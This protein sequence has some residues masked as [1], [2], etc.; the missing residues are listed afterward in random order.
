MHNKKASN[1]PQFDLQM[2]PDIIFDIPAFDNGYYCGFSTSYFRVKV[3][4]TL[5]N[6][7][8]AAVGATITYGNGYV[9]FESGLESMF[10]RVLIQ[11]ASGNLLENFENYNYLYCPT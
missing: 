10:R 6:A 7:R 9:R 5:G 3:D 2:G 4:I 11:D 1:G 8:T